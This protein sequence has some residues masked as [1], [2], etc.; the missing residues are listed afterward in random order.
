MQQ[1]Y[2]VALER[3][4]RSIGARGLNVI[5]DPFG[6]RCQICV[7]R[8]C[9]YTLSSSLRLFLPVDPIMTGTQEYR[10]PPV[11]PRW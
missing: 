7:M 10:D 4:V 9:S 11:G 2:A 1:K 3:S 6:C 5:R 8:R